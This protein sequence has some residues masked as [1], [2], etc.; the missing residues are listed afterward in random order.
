MRLLPILAMLLLVSTTAV[1]ECPLPATASGSLH[2]R[3]AAERL[4]Y[5][6]RA[7]D[8]DAASARTWGLAWG[9]VYGVGTL[10]QIAAMPLL[11]PE[12]QKDFVVGIASTAVGVGF[13]ILGLPEV[14]A[15]AP[16]FAARAAGGGDE[17][18]L[19][20]EAERLIVKDAANEL[21]GVTWYLHAANVAFNLGLGLVIGLGFGHWLSA[22]INF[23]TGAAIGEGTIFTLPTALNGAWARYLSGDLGPPAPTAVQLIP[24]PVAGGMGL[25]LRF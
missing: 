24:V 10:G 13:T 3:P 14:M 20:A 2:G 21:S 18:E 5:L 6:S 17:C 16:A 23:V 19:L 22:L 7:L 15:D 4:R 11:G 1:A 9:T 8:A 25:A 12:D